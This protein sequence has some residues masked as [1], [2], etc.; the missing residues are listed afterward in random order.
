MSTGPISTVSLIPM[1][2]SLFKTDVLID[3]SFSFILSIMLPWQY[4]VNTQKLENA[5]DC[6]Q[7]LAFGNYTILD[8]RFAYILDMGRALPTLESNSSHFYCSETTIQS[9]FR[10]IDSVEKRNRPLSS[11]FDLIGVSKCWSAFPW[12]LPWATALRAG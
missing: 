1:Y 9:I 11:L 5:W 2:L 3:A 6:F 4:E 8:L 10:T 7:H 12:M